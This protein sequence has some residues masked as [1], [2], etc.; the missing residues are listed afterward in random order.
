[1]QE[2]DSNNELLDVLIDDVDFFKEEMK[3]T[4][5]EDIYKKLEY[6]SSN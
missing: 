6:F 1:M 3:M 4:I 5:E 2:Y